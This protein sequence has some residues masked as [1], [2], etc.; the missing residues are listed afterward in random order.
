MKIIKAR[1]TNFR[2]I[3]DT[4]EITFNDFNTIIGKNDA[5]KSTI[6]KALN[7]FLNN[8]TFN[9][10]NLNINADSPKVIIE[11][12]FQIT[13][14][15]G[16]IL[17]SDG[18]YINLSEIESEPSIVRVKKEWDASKARIP[19]ET[20]IFIKK[21]EEYDFLLLSKEQVIE[22][23]DG[24]NLQISDLNYED[25]REK[26]N[27][28]RD[29][30]NIHYDY[31]YE[32]LASTGNSKSKLLH[33]SL[34]LRLPRF[35]YFPADSSLSESDNAIQNFFKRL[36]QDTIEDEL[37]LLEIEKPI[38][39]KLESVF[40]NIT[41]KI[42]SV[43]P[44]EDRV[45][46]Q[47]KFDWT[48]LVQTSFQS[49]TD[50]VGIPLSS[51]GDG[52]RR[53][54]MMSYFE[55]L[56]E[57]ATFE[58]QNIIF[59]FEEPETFLHPSAQEN[60]FNKLKS[61][62]E[63]DYQIMVT[64]HS[65]IIVSNSDKSDL[66]HIIRENREYKVNL[67]LEDVKGIAQDLGITFDNQFINLFNKAEL[68]FL[69][70]GIDDVN[71]FYHICN[72]YKDNGLIEKTFEE[73]G[74]IPVPVG[75][76]DSIKHWVTLDLLKTLNKPYYIFLDSDKV[77][78]EAVSPNKVKLIEFGFTEEEEF[79]VTKKRELENYIP[80]YALKRLVPNSNLE[81]DDWADV[82]LLCKTSSFAG[83]LGGK[84]VAQRHFISLT[85]EE[86]RSAFFNGEEDEFLKL[87]GLVRN[88]MLIN[89]R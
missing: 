12:F 65:P 76:C 85:F 41:E 24:L 48:K 20:Y 33:D 1:I 35:E 34:K 36:A 32:K 9:R 49:G 52:F 55:Y 28:K 71:A 47:I 38:K 77:S 27:Q 69:V 23:C 74:I 14:D 59:G 18:T 46:P 62:C 78:A 89:A 84:K 81:Y 17:L 37:N 88:K 80:P 42:N 43:V 61:M 8:G 87:Y 68:L 44:E 54:T 83:Q 72:K 67:N 66:I 30:L 56:A 51:R 5:G 10:D 11:L 60:L 50:D 79:L 73:M 63:N 25:I 26:L 64:S 15:S 3:K 86:L 45:A 53:I 29:E 13:T 70:E 75:G 39:N 6:L 31:T 19:C 82:K 2:G 16:P 21:Y 58:R 40:N 22:F 57:Q 7:L 4:I